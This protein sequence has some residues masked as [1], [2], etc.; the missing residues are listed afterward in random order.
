M[1]SAASPPP[2]RTRGPG[3]EVVTEIRVRST[4]E[5]VWQE[6]QCVTGA[7]VAADLETDEKD[8]E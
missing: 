7:T 4:P 2:P 8:M 6:L 5:R 1:A 3:R